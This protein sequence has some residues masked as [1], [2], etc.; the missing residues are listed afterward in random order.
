MTFLA[1][2]PSG[3]PAFTAARSMSPVEICGMPY[4]WHRNAACVPLPAP[5]APNKIS[6]MESS[7]GLESV[8]TA[9]PLL[10]RAVAPVGWKDSTRSFA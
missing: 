4:F 7:D 2:R 9:G 10:T 8:G 3:V 5:G 6:L 1:A